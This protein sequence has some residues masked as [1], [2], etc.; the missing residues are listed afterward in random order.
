MSG[1]ILD[2]EAKRIRDDARHEG[3]KEGIIALIETCKEF[4]STIED[5]IAK[6]KVKFN[7]TEDNAKN[8]VNLYWGK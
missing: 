4:N 1:Q 2:F 5:T 7:L 8:E 6:V 3:R